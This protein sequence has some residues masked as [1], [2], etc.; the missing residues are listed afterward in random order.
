MTEAIKPGFDVQR[1]LEWIRN[2]MEPR[3]V[4]AFTA[5]DERQAAYL[6]EYAVQ[7]DREKRDE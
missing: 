6:C 4:V 1:V 5:G 3:A 2:G 7:K